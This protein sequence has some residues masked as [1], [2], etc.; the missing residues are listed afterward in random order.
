LASFGVFA[1]YNLDRLPA[2]L[3]P[4]EYGTEWLDSSSSTITIDI[5]VYL[6]F[7]MTLPPS[8]YGVNYD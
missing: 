5:A 8:G 7:N 3:P 4:L 1:P 6:L 2:S